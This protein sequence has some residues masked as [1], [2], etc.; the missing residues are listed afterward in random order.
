MEAGR[1]LDKTSKKLIKSFHI[2]FCRQS[3]DLTVT[4]FNNVPGPISLLCDIHREKSTLNLVCNLT[5]EINW[6]ESIIVIAIIT[7]FP[8]LRRRDDLP[9][10]N[11]QPKFSRQR[12]MAF[13]VGC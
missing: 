8:I 10:E 9:I 6:R 4:K 2:S 12:H 7:L 1:L 3:C 13:G 5:K 11:K